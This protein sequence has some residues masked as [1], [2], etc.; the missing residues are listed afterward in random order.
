LRTPP[1]G[2]VTFLFTDIEGS[3]RRWEEGPDAMR[4][5][6]Q[7]HDDLLTH[8]IEAH[9]GFVFKT[10]GDACC[11]AFPTPLQALSA[12][13][14][15]QRLIQSE[16]WQT[17]P[18][19]V[20]IAINTGVA[21]LQ[22]GD[23]LG[24]PVNRTA[25][26]LA[27][28]HGGQILVSALTAEL[29]R[30][31][32]PE[33][34]ELQSLGEHTLR[35]LQQ[36]ER[37]YQVIAQG[38]D[39]RF[40]PLRTPN[41]ILTN[42]PVQ[43]TPF[44]GR[45]REV[46]ELR[47]LLA[48]TAI[49]LVTLTGPG[50]TGKTRLAMQVAANSSREFDDGV[51][52]VPL[53]TVTEPDLVT[54]AIAQNL[55][56]RETG[57]Q[58]LLESLKHYLREKRMLLVLDNF[59]QVMPAA[60]ILADL[61]ATVPG[62]TLM[63]TSRTILRVSGEHDFP[64][65]PMSVPDLLQLPLPD[66][67]HQFEAVELFLQR[68]VALKPDFALGEENARAVAEI[69]VRLD[70]LPLAIELAAARIRMM[71]PQAILSRLTSRLKLLTGGAR[72]LPARQQTLRG[73]IDWSHSLLDE[74]D[75]S[76][77]RRLA[78][79][80]GGFTLEA[81]EAICGG[82]TSESSHPGGEALLEPDSVLI[83]QLDVDMLDAVQSLIDKSLIKGA[84]GSEVSPRFAM[85][86]TIR[87]YAQERLD[88]S[89]ESDVIRRQ[90]AYYYLHMAEESEV[91][92]RGP[93]QIRW[94]ERLETEHDNLRAA[95][96]WAQ[97]QSD[98]PLGLRLVAALGRFWFAH[99]HL[100]EGRR[101]LEA[102]LEHGEDGE[103]GEAQHRARALNLAGRLAVMQGDYTTAQSR[104]QESLT[105]F[106][107]LDDKQGIAHVLNDFGNLASMQGDYT[108]RR[109]LQEESLLL[110][111]EIG[112]ASGAASALLQLGNVLMV[113][114]EHGTA[115][116]YIE[117]ALITLRRLGDVRGIAMSL[118]FLGNADQEEGDHAAAR[119][120]FDES[121]K[122]FRSLG[123]KWTIASLLVNSGN[124]VC[125]QRDYPTA[126]NLYREGMQ[127]FQELGARRGVA[128][129]L[130]G[131]AS[132]ALR[133]G[134][135]D[136]AGTLYRQSLQIRSELGNRLGIIE[137]LEGLARVI[138]ELNNPKLA[139]LFLAAADR[140]RNLMNSPLPPFE[141]AQH[142]LTLGKARSLLNEGEWQQ[143]WEEGSSLTLQDV[144]DK[145]LSG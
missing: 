51:I 94:L 143:V 45:Q 73:A 41:P 114:G 121:L 134:D 113:E 57:R 119:E 145:A 99:G 120:H 20:R 102:A 39:T 81:I 31:F 75:R 11:A 71:P 64:V 82:T 36:P 88:E 115:R 86:E 105:L 54:S 65:Q 16:Q 80:S 5:D 132:I 118:F 44:V 96:S 9:G 112:D 27:A 23:Y 90:H 136:R 2:T 7:R 133:Q 137:C 52:F 69:C 17:E 34:I 13:V 49:R 50:G 55:G 91:E 111:R 26:L 46:H 63:V 85:L 122:L 127:A 117:E 61:L 126:E 21:G 56:V 1:S 100:T 72:D 22:D 48:R 76:L 142:Q 74:N 108:E 58:P 93:D 144:V 140:H 18:L 123:D 40:P 29:I 139:A 60:T 124:A 129:A 30:L 24:P 68:A 4:S 135:L 98:W 38:L 87:E 97:E 47:E 67:L 33:D 106:R 89:G 59:E 6:L 130:S 84:D 107:S 103:G 116:Q 53:G 125:E 95:I 104:Y 43:P 78:I 131:L 3:T 138:I 110:F 37:V 14:Q 15:A 141:Q 25:R 109:T 10:V 35:D 8:V 19:R 101:H 92:L 70:G 42:L 32:L 12:A 62:L 28:G 83:P 128:D 79:F 77:F 66:Q